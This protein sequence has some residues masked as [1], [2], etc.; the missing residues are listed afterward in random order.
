[1]LAENSTAFVIRLADFSE[2]S[3]VV[4]L[5]TRDFGKICC[6]AKGAKRLKSAFDSALDLLSLC[7]ITFR[8]KSSDSLHLLTEAKLSHRFH[9]PANSLTHLY[10]GYY[11]AELLNVMTETDDP[12]PN[13]FTLTERCLAGL[14]DMGS[15]GKTPSDPRIHIVQFELAIL[16]ETGHIP[17]F[18]ACVL[19]H[20]P[21]QPGAKGR[22]WLSQGGLL[23]EQCGKPEYDQTT[24]SGGVI[25]ILRRLSEETSSAFVQRLNIRSEQWVELR[26][27]MN[28]AISYVIGKR[29][30]MLAYLNFR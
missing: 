16:R 13:L 4:T 22:Y 19:C 14:E 7:H 26:R 1:M 10:G 3:R 28:S 24:I 2:S 9:P 11:V 30:K 8:R 27:V 5:F 20:N 18:E 6:I 21:V 15:D 25:S 17:D 23:C 29:P 12:H